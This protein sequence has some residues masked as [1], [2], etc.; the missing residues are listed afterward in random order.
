M[1][2]LQKTFDAVVK[3][4]DWVKDANCRNMDTELFFPGDGENYDPFVREVCQECPVIEECLWY[5]NET[6]S[7]DGMFGGMTPRERG[8]WRAKTGI[9]VGMSKSDWDNRNR[10]YLQKPADEWSAS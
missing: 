2:D 3:A 6:A 10:G 8:K 9:S 4:K 1:N 7:H 5:S